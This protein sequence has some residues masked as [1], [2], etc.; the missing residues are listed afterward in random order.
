M[1][2]SS[3]DITITYVLK[4]EHQNIYIKQK[5]TEIKGERDNSTIVPK[6]FNIH[7]L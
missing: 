7:F 4:I 3:E 6:D 2:N 1:V 5:M